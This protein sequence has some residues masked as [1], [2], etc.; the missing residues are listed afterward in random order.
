MAEGIQGILTCQQLVEVITNYF[1][2]ALTADE[3]EQFERHLA[4]CRGCRIYLDQMRVTLSLLG[5]LNAEDIHETTQRELLA[6]F[7]SLRNTT[8]NR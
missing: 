7:R 6:A 8:E 4:L 1:E 5:A 3:R 2:G